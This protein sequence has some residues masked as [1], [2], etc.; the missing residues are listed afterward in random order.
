MIAPIVFHYSARTDRDLEQRVILYLT[1]LGCVAT[2]RLRVQA[3]AGEVTLR[4]TVESME[5]LRMVVIYAGRV[6]GVRKLNLQLNVAAPNSRQ[7][8]SPSKLVFSAELA[9]HF[10]RRKQDAA[11][12]AS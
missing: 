6:A 12:D 8:E 11:T 10:A 4:G 9:R 1:R 7:A 5:A 2:S 3:D